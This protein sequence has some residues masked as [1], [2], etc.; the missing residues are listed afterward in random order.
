VKPNRQQ[1]EHDHQ[2]AFFAWL[3]CN[4]TKHPDLKRFFAVP[5]GGH[6]DRGTAI[7]MFLEGTRRG[8]PDTCLPLARHGK[9]GLWIEF[10]AGDNQLTPD[11]VEWKAALE[12]EGHQVEI[13]R[14]WP[15]AAQLTVLY[16]GLTGIAIPRATNRWAKHYDR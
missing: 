1:I 15:E 3:R 10:K 9:Q 13:V 16:L 6:R 11:Q 4:E 14:E 12:R 2:S 8:V 5:N 7:K